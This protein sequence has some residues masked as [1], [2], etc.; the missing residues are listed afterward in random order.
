MPVACI[1]LTAPVKSPE[2]GSV[3]ILKWSLLRSHAERGCLGNA[4]ET[5]VTILTA[6][7]GGSLGRLVGRFVTSLAKEWSSRGRGRRFSD[8]VMRGEPETAGTIR[9]A[10]CFI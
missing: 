4:F 1:A 6:S 3:S 10:P 8:I 2:T 7:L 9:K 5:C